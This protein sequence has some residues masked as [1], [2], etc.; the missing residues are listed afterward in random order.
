[1]KTLLVGDLHLKAQIVLPL[2]EEK[3]R[4]LSCCRVIL[5][6]DYTDAYDQ[7]RNLDLYV[8]EL[9]Y[10]LMWKSKMQTLGIEVVTLLGNHDA[11]Y[12]TNNPK[13]YSVRDVGTFII[14]RDKLLK[15]GLQVAFQLEDYLISHA[16]YT[17]DYELEDWHLSI[18]IKEDVEKIDRLDKHV[19]RARGGQYRLGSPIWSDFDM[20][21]SI[22]PNQKHP[23]QIVGHTP[24]KQINIEQ[25]ESFRLIGIDTFTVIPKKQSPYFE[26]TGSGEILLY[27]NG[28][29]KIIP[30]P[31]RNDDVIQLIGSKFYRNKR[32]VTMRDIIFDF[33]K[34]SITINGNEIFLT[35]KEFDIFVYLFEREDKV[36]SLEEIRVQILSKYESGDP[37]ENVMSRLASKIETVNILPNN[38][39]IFKR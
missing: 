24:Q 1:M 9:D 34:W 36:V 3:V 37:D 26:Q 13:M 38:E 29:T 31:W 33:E 8:N 12:F 23:K 16:G 35:N 28:K 17:E 22:F 25:K 20:E 27:E 11:P 10:L 19:G 32:I 6:G 5:M 39:Y 2:I 21:L 4:K 14:V 15:L 7:T 18:L 30:L